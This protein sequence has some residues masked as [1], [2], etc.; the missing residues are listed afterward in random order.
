MPVFSWFPSQQRVVPMAVKAG[1]LLL[2]WDLALF[3]QG[4][5]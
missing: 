3:P 5:E 1:L 2:L 4:G